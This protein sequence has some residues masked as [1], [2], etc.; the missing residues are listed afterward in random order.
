MPGSIKSLQ[1]EEKTAT[2]N[3]FLDKAAMIAWHSLVQSK[4]PEQYRMIKF[5]QSPSGSLLH[6]SRRIFKLGE[7]HFCSLLLKA[8]GTSIP[9]MKNSGEEKCRL[10]TLD[11]LA[12]CIYNNYTL[13]FQLGE[14]GEIVVAANILRNQP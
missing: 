10:Y 2:L 13:L 14:A 12:A 5:Q 1:G 7:A 6:L 11:Y 4:N 9:V 8:V 3:E